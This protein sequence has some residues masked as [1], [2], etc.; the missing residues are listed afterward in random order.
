MKKIT[1]LLAVLCF[2]SSG[3]TAQFARGETPPQLIRGNLLLSVTSTI[4]LDGAWGSELMSLGFSNT[5]Y[6]YGSD[7]AED[8]Y[9]C[10]HYNLLPRAGYFVI[11]N[12][13]AGIEVILSGYKEKDAGDYDNWSESMVGI[14]PFVR[15]YYPM[16]KFYPFAEVE[17]LFGSE[18][19]GYNDNEY[20]SSLFL[21]GAYLG[22]AFP[23]G[24]KVTFD[25]EIG[26]ANATLTHK[27]SGIEDLD[28]KEITGGIVIKGGF[29]VYLP[30]K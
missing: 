11:D 29:S 17:V 14:G 21:L 26:Y 23:L 30:V 12:M 7:P 13:A 15:Y 1:L 4:A 16:E 18:K 24:D 28:S 22:V 27:G 8:A 5:K 20:K 10:T 19:S 9:K 25:V 6:K 2:A 3:A